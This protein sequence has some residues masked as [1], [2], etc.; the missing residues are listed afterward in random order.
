MPFIEFNVFEDEPSPD[1][2]ELLYNDLIRDLAITEHAKSIKD[3]K[4]PS[5]KWLFYIEQRKIDSKTPHPGWI[6]EQLETNPTIELLERTETLLQQTRDSWVQI[7][8]DCKSFIPIF[9]IIASHSSLQNSFHSISPDQVRLLIA[10]LKVIRI[11]CNIPF[12][13][14]E[15]TKYV[16]ITPYL[17]NSMIE[18]YPSTFPPIFSI[19]LAFL[20]EADSIDITDDLRHLLILLKPKWKSLLKILR[21]KIDL[22]FISSIVAFINGLNFALDDCQELRLQFFFELDQSGIIW[23]LDEI[24]DTFSS[25]KTSALESLL[26]TIR[27]DIAGLA[28]IYRSAYIN[29]FN[30]DTVTETVTKDLDRPKLFNSVLLQLFSI[31]NNQKT[32]LEPILVFL[33]NLLTVDRLL[34]S[35]GDYTSLPQAIE[36]AADYNRP[37]KLPLLTTDYDIYV[38]LSQEALF[39]RDD[40]MMSLT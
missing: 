12:G 26:E 4:T 36:V 32:A 9:S 22:N 21:C 23:K 20:F 19:L 3:E 39:V 16:D 8:F 2:I 33:H 15:I 29:P 30:L 31:V 6:R 35:R 25:I 7:F 10:A 18:K 14:T 37:I 1:D 5:E 40:D 38:R 24:S 28:T 27:S 11:C 13:V 34:M 17:V